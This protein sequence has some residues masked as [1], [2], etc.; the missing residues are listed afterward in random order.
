[1]YKNYFR[2]AG[3]GYSIG[4]QPRNVPLD[5]IQ[6]TKNRHSWF[7]AIYG[8]QICVRERVPDR[9]AS[10]SKSPAAVRT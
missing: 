2:W 4:P 10:H 8:L 3:G 1:M 6:H 9:R 7:V 5:K